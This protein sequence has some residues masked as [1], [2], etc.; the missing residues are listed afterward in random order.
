[1]LAIEC[2]TKRIVSWRLVFLPEWKPGGLNYA[3]VH[4]IAKGTFAIPGLA[5]YFELKLDEP[6]GKM[7]DAMLKVIRDGI[8]V[9]P[10]N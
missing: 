9:V 5:Y 7:L 2:R 10:E 1:M 8:S 3:H 6:D 4:Y